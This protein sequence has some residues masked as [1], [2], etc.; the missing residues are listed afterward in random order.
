MV[1]IPHLLVGNPMLIASG[2]EI[3]L[4]LSSVLL[5][6]SSMATLLRCKPKSKTT[7]QLKPIF[8]LWATHL[9]VFLAAVLV[10][11]SS[12]PIHQLSLGH[13]VVHKE[14]DQHFEQQ[15]SS[16]IQNGWSTMDI[17][18]PSLHWY[19]LSSKMTWAMSHSIGIYSGS[20]PVFTYWHNW[21][22]TKLDL[23][24]G[25]KSLVL[26]SSRLL[27][28]TE[29]S[30]KVVHWLPRLESRA[31]TATLKLPKSFAFCKPSGV[32]LKVTSL[33]I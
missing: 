2:H 20:F 6:H 8:K 5:T 16:L 1:I 30:S 10:N 18:R 15:L 4:L 17:P 11:Q 31:L 23:I 26:A 9:V 27:P 14:M 24:Y 19:G 21:L 7:S 25:K 28:N 13:G 32:R 33:P 22:G 3:P 29:H 12:M